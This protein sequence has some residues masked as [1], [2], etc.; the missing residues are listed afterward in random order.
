[1]LIA[2]GTCLAFGLGLPTSAAY[3]LVALL[4][5]PALVALDVPMLAA[6]LFVFYFA[7]VSAITPPIAIASMVAAN[8]AG[9]RFMPTAFLSVRLGLPGFLLPFLFIAHPE[10]LGLGG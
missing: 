2:A 5:A 8:I 1:L 9:A 10:I 3:F 7:N 6:H 4:G